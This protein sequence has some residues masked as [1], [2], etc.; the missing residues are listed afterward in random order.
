MTKTDGPATNE[1]MEELLVI[2]ACL[3]TNALLAAYEMAFVSVPQAEL[4]KCADKGSK[5]AK[6][7]LSL[8]KDPERT[9]SIIQV[10][11]TMVGA[12]SAA[13]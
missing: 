11:I 9:L 10:G 8:R 13:V 6:R 12:V 1:P 4:K 2:A 5:A 3:A 7:L